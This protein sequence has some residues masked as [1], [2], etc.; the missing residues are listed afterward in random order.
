[1]LRG[2]RSKIDLQDDFLNAADSATTKE[3]SKR[4][5]FTFGPGRRLCQ[6]IHI[7]EQSLFLGIVRF[8]WA[9]DIGPVVGSDGKQIMPDTDSFTQ[10]FVCPPTPFQGAADIE[11][12]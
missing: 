11:V 10:G 3:V 12:K 6:G 2:T 8:V 4:D 1:M 7:A 5:H 9:F